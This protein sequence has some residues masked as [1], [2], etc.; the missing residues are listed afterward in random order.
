MQQLLTGK[1]RLDGFTEEWKE[2]KLGEMLSHKTKLVEE[3]DYEPVSV[4]VLGIRLRSSIYSKELSNDYSKNKVFKPRQLCFGIGTNE[5][6]FGINKSCNIYCV[7]PAYKVFNISGVNDSFLEG[8]LRVINNKLSS[9]YM[10]VGA[11]QGKSVEFSG[12]LKHKINI[13]SLK[14]QTAIAEILSAADREISLLEK[15]KAH[16]ETQKRGLMQVLLTGKKRLV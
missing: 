14:E 13:P 6:V 2:V 7:S 11:R 16:L 3:N 9:K 5:I 15:K 8:L 1:K 12:L 10:I 4:G